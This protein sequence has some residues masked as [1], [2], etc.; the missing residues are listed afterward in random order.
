MNFLEL[1]TIFEKI[2]MK[3][4]YDGELNKN[5]DFAHAGPNGEPASGYAVQNYI[6][7]IDDKKIACG[8]TFEGGAKHYFFS[9]EEEMEEFKADPS[10]VEL[11]KDSVELTPMY[12]LWITPITDTYNIVFL[13]STGNFI[14]YTFET[15]NRNEQPVA[16]AVTAKYTLTQGGIKQT[17]TQNYSVGTEVNLNIDD[18][19]L[20]G[21]NIINIDVT[22]QLTKATMSIS[23]TYQVVNLTLIDTM[24]ISKVYKINNG[25]ENLQIPYSVSGVGQKIMEWYIDGERIT[26]NRSEDEINDPI[27]VRTKYISLIGYNQGLHNVQFRVGINIGG[28]IYYSPIHYREFIVSLNQTGNP[29]VAT[30]TEFPANASILGINDPLTINVIQFETFPLRLATFNPSGQYEN[31]VNVFINSDNIASVNCLEGEE[32]QVSI[33]PTSTGTKTLYLEVDSITRS[34]NLSIAETTLDI[35]EIENELELN[36]NANGK[37]NSSNDKN[38]WTDGVNHATLTGF[39]WTN[40]SGWVNNTLII[41][42]GAHI[43]FDLAPLETNPANEGKTIEIEFKTINVENDNATIIDLIN[44]TTGAGIKLTATELFVNS[45]GGVN[46]NRR[47]KSNEDLRIS[48]VINRKTGS[49][50]SKL[51]Q[52]YFNGILSMTKDFAETDQFTAPNLLSV[53]GID[54]GI[55]LKQIKIYN[56]A[57]DA[58]SIVN[59][60]ILYRPTVSEMLISYERNNLYERNTT[61]FDIDKISSYLPV[62][63]ITGDMSPIDNATDTKATTVVDIEYI[64][65]QNPSYSFKMKNAQ[66]RP[67]GTSSLTYPRKNLRLYTKKRDD[68][69]VYDADNNVVANKL[70]S[71]KPGAQPV[72]CWTLKADFAESSSTHNTG[73]ARIWNDVM[74]QAQVGGQYVLRTNAQQT[75]INNNFPYDV[76]TTVDGFPIVVFNRRTEEDPLTFLGKYNFNNDKSTESVFGFKGIPEFDNSN[77]QCWEFRDSGFDLA[78]FKTPQSGRT[79]EQEFDY[80]S[81]DYDKLFTQVWESRYPDTSSPDYSHLKR[82]A[83]WLNST[84]GASVIDSD[85]NS[86]TYNTLIIGDQNKFDKWQSEKS[87]YFDLPKL[88]AYYV[89]LIRFGAVDQTVKNAM[90]TTEDG[91]HWY[92]INYDNDTILGVRNDGLLKFGPEINRQSPDPELGGYA[93]AGHDS[94]LWNNFETD[95]ECMAMVRTIDSALFTAG[96]TYEGM[97]RMFNEEQ[98][99]KWAENVYNKDAMYKYIEPFLYQDK[100]Y[101]G[102]LQG[103]RNDHRKWWISNRFS[104]Y[105]AIYANASYENNAITLLIPNAPNT[106]TFTIESGKDFYY[107]WGQNRIPMEIDQFVAKDQN[108]TFTLNMDDWQIGTPL[109]I[110]APQYIKTLNLSNVMQY[111]GAQNFNLS[112]A[113]SETLGSKM[114]NLILGVDNP[115]IDNRRNTALAAISG[116]GNIVTL[117]NL[118]VAGFQ[119]LT[120]L[121]LSTLINLKTFKG[122]A[123]GLTSIT[124]ANGAPLTRIELPKTLQVLT[125]NTLPQLQT[126]GIVLEEDLNNT[127]GRNIYNINIHNCPKI[128]N[129]PTFLLNWLNNKLTTDDQCTVYIDNVNWTNVDPNDL[130]AIGEFK[131]N[132]GSLRLVGTCSLTSTTQEVAQQLMDIFGPSAFQQGAE[133]YITAPDNVYITGPTEILE[134]DQA[135]FRAVVFSQNPGTITWTIF[136]GSRTGTSLDSSTG[137]FTTTENS[138]GNVTFVI[139]CTHRPTVGSSVSKTYSVNVKNRYYPSN[140]QVFINGNASINTG[141]N[142]FTS[143]YTVSEVT[144]RMY[145]EW[146]LTGDLANY[147]TVQTLENNRCN[148]FLTTEPQEASVLGTLSLTLKKVINDSIV[149]NNIIKSVTYINDTIAISRS[150]NPYAMDVLYNA[151]LCNNE[152]YMTKEE[153]SFVTDVDLQPGTSKN[154][155]IFAKNASFRTYCQYFPE[156]KYFTGLT[157]IPE[158]LFNGCSQLKNISLPESNTC[159]SI[160]LQAFLDCS[161]LISVEM[162]NSITNIQTNAFQ[163]CYYLENINLSENLQVI[164]TGSFRN[165]QKLTTS[166]PNSLIT[167]DQHAFENTG[168]KNITIGENVTTLYSNTFSN[169]K[170]EIINVSQNNSYYNDGNGSNCIIETSTNKLLVGS[171]NSIIPSNIVTIAEYAFQGREITSITIPNSTTTIER[172]AFSQ[173]NLTSIIIPSTVTNIAEYTFSQCSNLTSI[174]LPSGITLIPYY[175]LERSGITSITI[176]DSVMTIKN[177]AFSNCSSLSTINISNNSNLT[178]IESAAFVNCAITSFNCP[179]SLRTI[180][181]SVFAD[182]SNLKEINL[183]EGLTTI[184]SGAFREDPI[185]RLHIPSTV[186]DINSDMSYGEPFTPSVLI[187]ITVASNNNYYNDGNGSNCIITSKYYDSKPTPLLLLGCKNSIIPNSIKTIYYHAF[188]NV[189]IASITMPSGI[190]WV[191]SESFLNTN[192]TQIEFPDTITYLSSNFYDSYSS[193]KH[194]LK[195]IIVRA[196]TPPNN[197]GGTWSYLDHIYVPSESVEAYKAASGWNSRPAIIEAIS[198]N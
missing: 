35:H 59:N 185:E 11:I 73:V 163:N 2:N 29:Y 64:N 173:S 39:E 80:Y 76:R 34:I 139:R 116:L 133:F 94:V 191:D 21:T 42:S 141:N 138:G 168:L 25:D 83:L 156:F 152:N 196:T 24:D 192:I 98:S 121:N 90:I 118:N 16:E 167:I 171:K 46:L 58:D 178:T 150:I 27:S 95:P 63:I 4:K 129:S 110:Y 88:A 23:I 144:G 78:L 99:E 51:V 6:K 143:D 47:Y 66:M 37:S 164:S 189:D 158:N 26:L 148:L 79:Y 33:T 108:H 74:K 82:L 93:Y 5:T 151:G 187:E 92:F 184:D 89:Y 10:K 30:A 3:Q 128:S 175:F 183:N 77:V 8:D 172:Y 132:G 69:I 7:S 38:I 122:H 130:L 137:V 123:S 157:W 87:Q 96:L 67:Q 19:L 103:S 54:T 15:T 115:N 70:Y 91:Q 20:E 44:S 142:I 179:S 195:T 126:S 162:S 81:S 124:F 193:S 32:S 53:G 198:N 182:C 75:A 170:L 62:M 56:T 60:Y 86:P 136:S 85:P 22:G 111:I 180:G 113:Y 49:T 135:Q 100:N 140:S 146:N 43:D 174:Q 188:K 9:S 36:F 155:S 181:H 13:G 52:V 72:N 28:T 104:L 154:T 131:Q 197:G 147:V 119:A 190:K 120:T 65:L 102:S 117:E 160:G 153:A 40:T 107:G 68:T 159:T 17:I 18:Y 97:I 101:L 134:G 84:E 145:A 61:N 112:S 176:P 41:P 125:L 14:R 165:C 31:E 1:I 109:R 166:L 177:N 161:S 169:C 114:K 48:I 186:T 149:C 105:D 45:M 55:I 194:L 71:F 106:S 12:N 57:L 50:L 127:H